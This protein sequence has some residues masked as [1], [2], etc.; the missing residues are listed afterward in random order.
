MIGGERGG[1]GAGRIA[2]DDDAARPLAIEGLAQREQQSRGQGV[3]ALAGRHEIEIDVGRADGRGQRAVEQFAMLA[4][5][6]DPRFHLRQPAQRRDHR[7]QLDGLGARAENDEK[8]LRR[9]APP[10]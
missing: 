3:E 5:N 1:H 10:A 7:R 2:L 6:A 4:G 9:H 8:P